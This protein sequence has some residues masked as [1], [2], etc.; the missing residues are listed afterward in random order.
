MKHLKTYYQ[1]YESYY[2]DFTQIDEYIDEICDTF[3]LVKINYTDIPRRG[4]TSEDELERMIRNKFII[5][6]FKND[7]IR[8]DIFFNPKYVEDIKI[9]LNK[10][11]QKF[12]DNSG[13][14]KYGD[15]VLYFKKEI[16]IEEYFSSYNN[17]DRN[18]T[19]VRNVIPFHKSN[20]YDDII[21][22]YHHHK[23]EIIEYVS[24][25]DPNLFV[26]NYFDNFCRRHSD[27]DYQ[28]FSGYK[29]VEKKL[30]DPI[31]A[32]SVRMPYNLDKQFIFDIT[33]YFFKKLYEVSGL[34]F[35]LSHNK[36]DTTRI[37]KHKRLDET[38][39]QQEMTDVL[40]ELNLDLKWDDIF[41]KK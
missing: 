36:Y 28:I 22:H 35:R 12:I 21:R 14:L 8:Y 9:Y 6:E 10:L 40:E 41:I 23:K 26:K 39:V 20:I 16:K 32:D 30:I 2:E 29:N 13:Y 34:I 31:D 37:T 38:S 5:E 7:S 4:N 11:V 18:M 15:S 17:K 27:W 19:A 33:P 1:I 3:D 25:I 24:H